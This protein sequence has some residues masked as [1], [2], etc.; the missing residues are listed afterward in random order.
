MVLYRHMAAVRRGLQYFDPKA[1]G[2]VSAAEFKMALT[3]LASA[4]AKPDPPY[5]DSQVHVLMTQLIE[6]GYNDDDELN[7]HDVLDAFAI[8]DSGPGEL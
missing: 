3:A 4:L 8:V 6:K 7:Y 5:S 1:T 2:I